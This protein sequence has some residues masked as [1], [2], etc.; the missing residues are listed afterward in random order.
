MATVEIQ[1]MIWDA[2][3]DGINATAARVKAGE[4]SASSAIARTFQLF[5]DTRRAPICN[6][7]GGESERLYGLG[8][9]H[10]L[11]Q[12]DVD[13]I[14]NHIGD[15][16]D[17]IGNTVEIISMA[18]DNAV[19]DMQPGKLKLLHK[20]AVLQ[21]D[22]GVQRALRM[23]DR[24]VRAS[25]TTLPKAPLITLS[26]S[27]RYCYCARFRGANFRRFQFGW[28]TIQTRARWLKQVADIHNTSAVGDR[29]ANPTSTA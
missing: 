7:D 25:E 1:A 5:R 12:Q 18:Y 9:G 21:C 10:T 3:V 11:T 8:A 24:S 22:V 28:L 26:W 23:F 20:I 16:N 4:L 14:Q 6:G 19:S 17:E 15:Y 29:P 2:L 13:D 27:W